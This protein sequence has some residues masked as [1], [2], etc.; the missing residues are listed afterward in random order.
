MVVAS[1]KHSMF[2]RQ[3]VSLMKLF[4]MTCIFPRNHLKYLNVLPMLV[5][6]AN[7]NTTL[8]LLNLVSFVVPRTVMVLLLE[9]NL[10]RFCT[11]IFSRVN[12]QSSGQVNLPL[13]QLNL[14]NCGRKLRMNPF[15][16]L[17]RQLVFMTKTH[18]YRISFKHKHFFC[19]VSLY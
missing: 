16:R 4:F 3:L 6:S 18:Y 9:H 8:P 19:I 15:P 7:S 14:S 12:L 11:R 1:V 13:V 2:S 5:S 10:K 17:K